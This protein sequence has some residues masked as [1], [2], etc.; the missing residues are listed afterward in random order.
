MSLRDVN[1][2][3]TDMLQK[4]TLMLDAIE[5]QEQVKSK[6]T[7]YL[8]YTSGMIQR[9]AGKSTTNKSS[10]D[11]EYD[12]YLLRA[13]Y[14][15]I[16]NTAIET[17]LGIMHSKPPRIELPDSMEYLIDDATQAGETIFQLLRR[18]NEVQLGTGR[19]G[20]LLDMAEVPTDQNQPFYLSIYK[21]VTVRNWFTGLAQDE[22][23][24]KFV[25]LDE[26]QNV[27]SDGMS[28]TWEEMTRLLW[29][30][31][32]DENGD[33]LSEP[34]YRANVF[35]SDSSPDPGTMPEPQFRGQTL[36]EIPFVFIN[37]KDILSQPDNPP[38]LGLANL[39]MTIYRGEAD[40]RQNLFMQGQDTLVV[41]GD[42]EDD[43]KQTQ[44]GAGARLDVPKGG[45]AKYIGVDSKGLTEQR[46]ALQNDYRH[47]SGQTAKIQD[48]TGVESGNALYIRVSAKTA[49]LNQIAL[50]GAAALEKS[51]KQ[52]AK[53]SG[54]NPDDVR[55]TPNLD[56]VKEAP[57]PKD[58]LDLT[59]AIV[60]GAPLS[61]E[62]FHAWLKKNEYTTKEYEEELD[63]ISEQAP[64]A[65]TGSEI[66]PDDLIE[67][68]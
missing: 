67:D 34:I 64:A 59:N 39:T 1:P 9:G 50:T 28:W 56:F 68:A 49:T 21:D 51:L 15:E 52:A 63:S 61:D 10:G 65:P 47:A 2:E 31:E 36:D 14:P 3:Y 66:I 23:V 44:V 38:L 60:A 53:W 32:T 18:I 20:L 12:S 46:E 17:C 33:T 13:V 45:D 41:I 26:S 5:G 6:K 27:L 19:L 62:S 37:S 40:Y 54:A 24:I 4:W 8:P 43:D 11:Q 57:T 30:Q 58:V 22:Q 29:L 16:V 7:A 42:D 35:Q 25:T 48:S 55:V